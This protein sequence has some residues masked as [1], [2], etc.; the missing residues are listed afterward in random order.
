MQNKN[1]GIIFRMK[2]I[3]DGYVRGFSNLFIKIT[4]KYTILIHKQ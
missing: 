1:W 4:V 2:I 3:C